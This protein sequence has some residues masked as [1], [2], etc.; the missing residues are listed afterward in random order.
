[1]STEM[2]TFTSTP[3]YLDLGIGMLGNVD[4]SKSTTVGQLITGGKDNGNG[5]LRRLISR[6]PH[7]IESGR[8][9]DTA[10]HTGIFGNNRITFV[11][12]AGHE[13]YLKTTISG[14]GVLIPDLLLLCVDKYAPTYKM[15]KEHIGLALRMN[16]PFAILMTKI[17]MYDKEITDVSLEGLRKIIKKASGRTL[18]EVS[19]IPDVDEVS[20]VYRDLKS[21]PVFHISNVTHQG[22]DLLRDF[23]SKIG[24]CSS[25]CFVHSK[26]FM[27]DKSYRVKGIGL[28]VTGFNGGGTIS[29][30]DK[31]YLNGNI[32]VHIR[33]IHNDFREDVKFLPANTR[34]CLALRTTAEWIRPGSV[35][36]A[37]PLTL[38]KKFIACVEILSSHSTS[39]TNGY[40]TV[41]HCGPIRRTAYVTSLKETIFRGGM[42]GELEFEF[43][44]PAWVEVGQSIFFREGRIIGDGKIISV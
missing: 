16:I 34:G 5:K 30:G 35:I 11:D 19:T 36:S 33:T 29:C 38:T 44:N 10:Y 23:L 18:Q 2:S 14:L 13:R 27:I 37:K 21:V 17:D 24:Q 42:K 15:T 12:L 43:M 4:S 31:M 6:H 39:I 20:N 3:K 40:Q 25:S 7:E 28:V 8:T 41:I 32:E 22:V 9:S 1:M 26:K